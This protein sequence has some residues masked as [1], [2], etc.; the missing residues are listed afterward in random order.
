[1]SII[2]YGIL[3]FC[4][5]FFIHICLWRVCLP[6]NQAYALLAIF[7]SGLILGIVVLQILV[8]QGIFNYL[9]LCLFYIAAMFSYIISYS[10]IEAESPSLVIIAKIAKAG[11]SGVGKEELKSLMTDEVLVIP[12]IRDLVRDGLAIF[13]NGKYRLTYKGSYFVG[14]FIFFRKLLGRGKGG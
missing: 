1:M 4:F 7:I 2:G 14:I 11:G 12:R 10:A 13:D 8:P 9:R 6:R 5:S 3:V